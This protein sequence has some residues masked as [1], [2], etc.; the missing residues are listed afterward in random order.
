MIL[1]CPAC[2]MRYL[3]SEGSIGPK[4]RRVRCA[5]CGHQWTQ[6]P[7]TGLDEALFGD[8]PAF[9]EQAGA[10]E[11]SFHVD[12]EPST[13]SVDKDEDDF[14]SILRKEI[15]AT[16]IPQ[17][18]H[19]DLEDPVLNQL[20]K[21][22]KAKEAK[23]KSEKIGGFVTAAC[24]WLLVF[25]GLLVLQPQISRAWPPSNLL[26][27][28]VGMTPVMPGEGLALDGLH[29]ELGEGH[30]ALKGN[31]INLR[32]KDTKVPAVMASIVDDAG[33]VIDRLLI[34][35]P[36]ARIKPEGQVE[37]DVIYPKLPDGATN[38]TFA[39]S[40]IKVD[41]SEPAKEETAD[42]MHEEKP[43][44]G[45]HSGKE[46]GDHPADSGNESAESE[47]HHE[48]APAAHH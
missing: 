13:A 40:F 43:A 32:D 31:I 3:V 35:P 12:L 21:D 18:V 9:L 34:A 5:N 2:T 10:E 47:P 15:E 17:G 36:I 14:Q 38:V 4:G 11:A 26:Y 19:P 8:A 6:E 28:L 25:A 45:E 23:P 7:E 48:D 33:K 30:I 42:D 39:F 20:M 1:T 24:F 44:E 22:K 29:A 37:F 46:P 16:P 41:A 27:D